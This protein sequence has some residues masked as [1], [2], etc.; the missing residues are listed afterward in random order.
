MFL[1]DYN[2]L[3]KFRDAVSNSIRKEEGFF[4]RREMVSKSLCF[5]FVFLTLSL[6]VFVPELGVSIN[7]AG[8][9]YRG[10]KRFLQK[11]RDVWVSRFIRTFL[12]LPFVCNNFTLF[13]M[14]YSVHSMPDQMISVELRLSPPD[15]TRLVF[16]RLL[17]TV[18]MVH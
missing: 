1:S 8:N 13:L 5:L 17:V 2:W 3:V 4:F 10:G 14:L 16:I 9:K 7:G 15:M 6:V 12:T 18:L 11:E